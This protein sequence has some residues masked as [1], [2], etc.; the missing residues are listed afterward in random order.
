MP[1]PAA[2]SVR[3]AER[4]AELDLEH[5]ARR[6]HDRVVDEAE[7]DHRRG[8][9]DEE[10]AELRARR[11]RARRARRD[12]RARAAAGSSATEASSCSRSPGGSDRI[13]LSSAARSSDAAPLHKRA[14]RAR[15]AARRRVRARCDTHVLVVGAASRILRR[16]SVLGPSLHA[17]P[18][19]SLCGAAAFSLATTSRPFPTG[20]APLMS[21]EVK[22]AQRTRGER[23]R[24]LRMGQGVARSRRLFG[25][26]RVRRSVLRRA[27]RRGLARV[28]LPR[29]RPRTRA[30]RWTRTTTRSERSNRA[31]ACAL[32]SCGRGVD[33]ARAARAA[34]AAVR[35]DRFAAHGV[36]ALDLLLG[37][38]VLA[39][40]ASL[41]AS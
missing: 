1:S 14:G 2:A 15:G 39:V 32:D 33:R 24:N 36:L 22:V 12:R 27:G 17:A 5:L 23:A 19:R 30:R 13:R 3:K 38:A 34:L 25:A 8:R 6:D 7:A 21:L 4:R 37:C 31:A 40:C 28:G 26:I 18:S 16:L 10:R 9:R 35:R 41:A 11:R 29:R 20:S